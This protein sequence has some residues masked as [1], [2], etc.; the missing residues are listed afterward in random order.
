MKPIT[1]N[2]KIFI[3]KNQV[4]T[5]C[6][7]DGNNHPYCINCFYVFD[8]SSAI[9]IFKSSHSTKHDSFIKSGEPTSGTI[10]E[11]QI[12]VTKLKGIQFT[13]ILINQQQ[14]IENKLQLLYT[15]KFPMSIAI[16][17]YLWG[18]QLQYLKFTDNSFVFRNKTI[19]EK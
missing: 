10:I 4:S 6:F 11:D 12:D 17:G 8:S 15:T 2:I 19:W 5:V 14:I 18:I 13:G 7:V 9:L 16:P 1:E 3:D